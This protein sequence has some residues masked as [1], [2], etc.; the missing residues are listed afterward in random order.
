MRPIFLFSLL[1]FLGY[2]SKV[3]A[4]EDDVNIDGFC[5]KVYT[6]SDASLCADL[7][8]II[9]E[10]QGNL[11]IPDSIAYDG[12]KIPVISISRICSDKTSVL[13]VKFPSSL[14]AIYSSAFRGCTNLKS[15]TLPETLKV[16]GDR[17]FAD[18]TSLSSFIVPKTVSAIGEGV[19]SGCLT[20]TSIVVEE[21]NKTYT[22]QESNN[23]IVDLENEVLLAATVNVSNPPSVKCIGAYTFAK[24]EDLQEVTLPEGLISIGQ[25]AFADCSV[26]SINIPESV[27]YIDNNAF[28]G[29]KNLTSIVFPKGLE[30][31][32]DE[33]FAGCESIGSIIIPENITSIGNYAFS[34]CKS[35]VSISVPKFVKS[36]GS[37]VFA[38]CSS[39]KSV[40][41]F[42][43]TPN[44]GDYCFSQCTSLSEV[45]LSDDIVSIGKW[46]FSNCSNL[47]QIKFP[48]SL[49]SIDE[50]AF[51]E[52]GL[53]EIILPKGITKITKHSFLDCQSIQKIEFKGPLEKIEEEAFKDCYNLASIILPE[54]TDF[55]GRN[56]F[57]GC[58]NLINVWCMNALPC[59]LLASFDKLDNA[60]LHVPLGSKEAYIASNWSL[61]FANIEEFAPTS[62]T[63]PSE[64]FINHQSIHPQWFSL[65]GRPLTTPPTRKGIYIKD[66]KKVMVK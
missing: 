59:S 20:L 41:I 53:T 56:A 54:T 27:T 8:N 65:S 25:F 48:K 19:L 43:P 7:Y 23:V 33:C 15:I 21:G 6:Q 11:V 4:I 58:M 66:G 10:C 32:S 57:K 42:G 64:G 17:A 2:G 34:S 61:C 14:Q 13:S 47:Q 63:A 38:N 35:L 9:G 45:V 3:K 44:I 31:I 60:V 49:M 46:A 62:I 36:I 22:S 40:K 5:Y 24:R 18:C 55:I 30:K 37:G 1:L 29:C 26:H 28:A 39:L 50:A 51:T 12:Q 16:I 52:S